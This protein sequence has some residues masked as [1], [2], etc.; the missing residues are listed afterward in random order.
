M[1]P[2]MST[3]VDTYSSLS[4]MLHDPS[5]FENPKEFNPNRF[6]ASQGRRREDLELLVMDV[7]GLGRR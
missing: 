7:F 4:G 1:R 6:L 3:L 2:F 5:Y